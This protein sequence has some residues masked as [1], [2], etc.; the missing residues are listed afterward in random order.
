MSMAVLIE[1]C[2]HNYNHVLLL[3]G[4]FL[5]IPHFL[6]IQKVNMNQY[7]QL[8]AFTVN[9]IIATLLSLPDLVST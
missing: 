4:K 6:L 8:G 9:H 3:E 1:K 5:K 7:F 2:T